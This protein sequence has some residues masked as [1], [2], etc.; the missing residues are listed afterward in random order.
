MCLETHSDKAVKIVIQSASTSDY[1]PSIM[2]YE[3]R[4]STA[5]F[6][7]FP[8]TESLSSCQKKYVLCHFIFYIYEVQ[9]NNNYYLK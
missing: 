1:S 6:P 3:R 2:Q 8:T 7:S 9:R 5:L 4:F